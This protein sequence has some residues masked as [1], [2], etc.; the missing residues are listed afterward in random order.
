MDIQ[1]IQKR[2]KELDEKYKQGL[3]QLE[4]LKSAIQFVKG[5]YSILEEM[6]KEKKQDKKKKKK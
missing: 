1:N 5:Q 4:Q 3:R 2:K 6:E